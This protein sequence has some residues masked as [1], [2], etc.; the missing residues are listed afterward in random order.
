MDDRCLEHSR[1][2]NDRVVRPGRARARQDGDRLAP[3]SS[4]AAASNSASSGRR[5]G[6]IG[7]TKRGLSPSI[8]SSDTSPGKTSTATPRCPMAV[9]IARCS[10]AGIC[11]GFVTI[12]QKW[13]HSRNSSVGCVSWK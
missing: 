2:R 12:S 9:R 4:V 8:S 13:L 7:A 10:S 3:F 5:T 11:F 1:E 6:S